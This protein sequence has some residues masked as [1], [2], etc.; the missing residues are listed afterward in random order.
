M[1]S[2]VAE[3]SSEHASDRRHIHPFRAFW[4]S[5]LL[6][7]TLITGALAL[8]L[9]KVF[10]YFDYLDPPTLTENDLAP[11]YVSA[12]EWREGG[13]PYGLLIPMFERVIGPNDLAHHFEP[14]Q[15]NAHPPALL[16]FTVPLTL[17]GF[18]TARLI[19]LVAMLVAMFLAVYLFAREV[20]LSKPVSGAL[21][22]LA[23]SLPVVSYDLRW[24]QINGLLLLGLVVAWRDLK[25]GN[26]RRAGLVLGVATALKIFPWIL[27]IPVLRMGRRR[28]AGWFAAT[29]AVVTIGSVLALG[30]A[31][32]GDF[33]RASSDNQAIWSPAPHS[34]SLVSAPY[35]WIVPDNWND[36]TLPVPAVVPVLAAAALV[37]CIAAALRTHGATTGDL[38]WAT[39]PIMILASP[40]AW[41]HY[42]VLLLP[43]PLLLA[44][45]RGVLSGLRVR[46]NAVALAILGFG[47]TSVVW[48]GT[49]FDVL[50]S[51]TFQLAAV[52]VLTLLVAMVAGGELAE[53]AS[54]RSAR[55]G[56]SG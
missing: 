27:L 11:D 36:P 4:S 12:R 42:L 37:I 53:P 56:G 54:Q 22:F 34:I 17:V 52:S 6:R 5:P 19:W 55:R 44:R 13:D 43:I 38:Y 41:A 2:D 32:A 51:H 10:T 20:S 48:I 39:I 31:S 15:R 26:D 40:I 3:K 25:R 50:R 30:P 45:R 33:L 16:L 29:A 18:S 24:A 47:T 23:L 35:R 46:S 7:W 14:N 9:L 1:R 8:S 28:G 49:A 21:A